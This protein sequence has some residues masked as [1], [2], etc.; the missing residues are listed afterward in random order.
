MERLARGWRELWAEGRRLLWSSLWFFLVLFAYYCIKPLRDALGTNLSRDLG[1]LYVVTFVA[2]LIAL[3]AYSYLVSRMSRRRLLVAVHGFFILC[4]G[5]FYLAISDI[6]HCSRATSAVFFVWVSVFSLYVVTLF[7]SVMADMYRE[8]DAKKWFGFLAASGSVGSVA[9]SLLAGFVTKWADARQ[10]MLVTAAALV[11]AVF[12]GIRF[13]HEST[14]SSATE[15]RQTDR[16]TGGNWLAGMTHVFR[17]RYLLAICLFVVLGKFAATFIYNALQVEL[18]SAAITAQARTELFSQI[19]LYAQSG[20]L[21]LQGVVVRLLIRHLGIGAALLF[22]CLVYAG[23][24]VWIGQ[25]STW[26]LLAWSHALQQIVSYGILVPAQ[27]VLFTVVSREDKYKAKGFIDTVVFRGSDVAAGNVCDGLLR[28][29]FS[30]GR[31]AVWMVPVTLIWLSLGL[32][33]G[34]MFQRRSAAGQA[35]AQ[36]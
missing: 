29:G 31:I 4:L 14:P 30:V 23:L 25:G 18:Q 21:L 36:A 9:G 3:A 24:F 16:G 19:N 10:L 6:E 20:T 32:I 7:W 11:L 2:T 1:K 33:L 28:A 13:L 12:V 17:T 8:E 27:H 34:L 35:N 22:P 26:S 15:K 5:G